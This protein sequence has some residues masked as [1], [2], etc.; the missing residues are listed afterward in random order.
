MKSSCP[1]YIKRSVWDECATEIETDGG[2]TLE[3]ALNNFR[4][5]RCGLAPAADTFFV[6]GRWPAN[7]VDCRHGSWLPQSA[8]WAEARLQFCAA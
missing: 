6:L 7:H 5:I 3:D 1:I 4:A 8:V 2:G